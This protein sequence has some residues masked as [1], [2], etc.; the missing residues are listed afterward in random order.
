MV[1]LTIVTQKIKGRV[2]ELL[3]NNELVRMWTEAAV[4]GLAVLILH[5]NRGT[6][7]I[8]KVQIC[9]IIT[10]WIVRNIKKLGKRTQFRGS[11]FRGTTLNLP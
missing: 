7:K 2:Q 6:E 8:T 10:A 1:R 5:Y 3:V 4:A 11:L 9:Y